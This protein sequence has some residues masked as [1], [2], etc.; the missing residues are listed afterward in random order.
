MFEYFI[1]LQKTEQSN[2][3][4]ITTISIGNKI[5]SL[6]S[7]LSLSVICVLKRDV[8]HHAIM[9]KLINRVAQLNSFTPFYPSERDLLHDLL[10]A[11]SFAIEGIEIQEVP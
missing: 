3:P 4:F 7:S 2:V 1:S 6:V 8:G 9:R 10:L 11:I 5:F